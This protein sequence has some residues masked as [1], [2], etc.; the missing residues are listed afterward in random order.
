MVAQ[1][2]PKVLPEEEKA[3]KIPKPKAVKATTSTALIPYLD[4][5]A[6]NFR[7]MCTGDNFK[8]H[9]KKRALLNCFG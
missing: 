8:S 4:I 6:I 9:S 3:A 5:V 1:P 7:G 2:K